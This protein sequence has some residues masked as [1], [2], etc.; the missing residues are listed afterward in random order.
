MIAIYTLGMV[1]VF[2]LICVFAP[3]V[4]A[5]LTAVFSC[6]VVIP[7]LYKRLGH[8]KNRKWPM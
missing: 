3:E 5:S 8:R 6:L 4:A 2:T 1:L 7:C